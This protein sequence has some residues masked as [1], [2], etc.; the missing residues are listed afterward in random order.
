VGGVERLQASLGVPVLAHPLT[1]E[2]LA[3]QGIRIDGELQDGQRTLLGDYPVLILHT[4]GHARG[5]LCFL[6]EDQRS[7]LCGDMVSGVSMIVVDPPEGD[8]DDYLGSL[9]KLATLRPKTLFPGHGPVIK[10]AEAKLREYVDHRLWREERILEA[11][12]AGRRQPS[13]M[14]PTVYDDV[15]KQ[16]WPL[17]ER[18]ILAHLARLR[19]HGRIARS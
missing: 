4:P 7:L 15:P 11:W 13:E 1:A 5:H 10:N 8:M 12:N 19:K 17:A 2:R 14:L 16:A 6:E 9:A 18:Q 3:S